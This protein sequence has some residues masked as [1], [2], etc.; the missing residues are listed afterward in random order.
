MMDRTLDGLI[1]T[2][3]YMDNSQVGSLDREMHL[4]HLEAFFA[5]L[6]VNGLTI[7]LNK[8]VFAIPS[9]EFL[10]HNTSAA[11]ST[12]ADDHSA[13]I[14]SCPPPQGIK[15]LQRFLSMVNFSA[16][17]CQIAQKCCAPKLTS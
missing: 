15:Q 8:C 7:N 5:A 4:R 3:P 13:K 10:G 9:L 12:P 17:F 6:A 16:V 2:F 11:G 14:K 1:G